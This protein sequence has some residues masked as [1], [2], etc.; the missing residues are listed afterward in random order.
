MRYADV[1]A[2]STVD[3]KISFPGG[4]N[5]PKK[6]DLTDS[7]GQRRTQLVK[8]G[9]DDLRQDAVMEQYFNLLNAFL[10]TAPA[11]SS[12]DLHI[13][14]FKVLPMSPAAGLLE[15]VHNTAPI[16]EVITASSAVAPYG[17]ANYASIRGELMAAHESC[18]SANKNKLRA[19]YVR[20]T[21]DQIASKMTPVLHHH[22]LERYREPGA[23]FEA[24]LSYTRSVAASSMAGHIIG[25][26]DRHTSNILLD[27]STSEV[28]HI[29][30]GI[31]FEQGK[32]LA[33]PERVPFRLTRNLVDGMGVT[34][35]EG[36]MRRCCEATLR[37]LRD[38][39]EP[40]LTLL[41]VFVHDPLYKWGLTFKTAARRQPGVGGAGEQ[42]G[43]GK[44]MGNVDAN[45]TLLRIRQKLEGKESGDIA[46]RS[47]EGQVAHL[48][49]EAM[50]EDNLCLMYPGWAQL[51]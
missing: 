40:L 47:V 35:V 51:L 13:R 22:F 48:L 29:D 7:H 4:I 11:T 41:E 44:S 42:N 26:G 43:E 17:Y 46:A 14:T 28:V 36:A 39:R 25:L 6:L 23:W 24:R 16:G 33:T 3:S 50:D 49:Q 34:G 30:L 18:R 5:M 38:Q 45:R 9:S 37:V 12:R 2:V 32:H 8:G 10:Q 1:P 27:T 19:S 20:P 31:A 15:W 21:F